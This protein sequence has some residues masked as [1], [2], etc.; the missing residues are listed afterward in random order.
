METLTINNFTKDNIEHL[1]LSKIDIPNLCII[2]AH[3]TETIMN[4]NKTIEKCGLEKY[5]IQQYLNTNK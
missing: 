4:I 2:E 1:I 3:E 5:P